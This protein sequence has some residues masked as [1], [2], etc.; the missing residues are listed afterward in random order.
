VGDIFVSIAAYRDTELGPT[1]EDGLAKARFPERLRFG[2]CWQH[3]EDEPRP[4]CFD[5]P[6]DVVDVHRTD[7]RGMCWAR[8]QAM[9]LYRGEKWLLQLD[10]HHRFVP[11]WDVVL[12]QQAAACESSRPVLT[13]YAPE[14]SPGAPVPL[15]S[16]P[17]RIEFDGF[18]ADGIARQRPG[19][20][21][22]WQQ[23]TRPYRGRFASGHLFFAPGQF[24]R[25]V[26]WDPD[27]YF[28]GD[29]IVLA[30]RAFTHGYDLFVPSRLVLWH[31]YTGKA[32]P[33]HWDDHADDRAA[34]SEQYDWQS[35]QK[36]ARLLNEPWVGEFG[37]GS[38]RTLAEYEAY[39]GISFR[40]RR[41]QHFTRLH[42]EPPNPPADLDWAE[43]ED[44]RTAEGLPDTDA[45]GIGR[46]VDLWLD[47]V[48]DDL[49]AVRDRGE[50]GD[51]RPDAHQP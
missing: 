18:F 17:K 9:S 16:A 8:G 35:R 46:L 3:D 28:T 33:K 43:Q 38:E 13:T 6:V 14:Y 25:D 44:D 36:V 7:S 50:E 15:D 12:E 42:R 32:R 21:E 22:G 1:I 48:R 31:A 49:A 11:G 19:R 51:V 41:A 45:T 37:L 23:R 39:A 4:R 5:G 20:I 24:V 2:V 10:S 27:L 47:Q 40:H 29:E 34:A 26:P 30:V